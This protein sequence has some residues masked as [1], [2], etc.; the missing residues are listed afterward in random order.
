MR[1][2]MVKA[3]LNP[4]YLSFLDQIYIPDSF[5]KICILNLT[6][7]SITLTKVDKPFSPRFWH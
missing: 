1:R 7:L 5:E 2:Y 6:N 3:W 4:E